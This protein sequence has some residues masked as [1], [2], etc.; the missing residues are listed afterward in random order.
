MKY[1]KISGIGQASTNQSA[2]NNALG[3]HASSEITSST[4][5]YLHD[6]M[7]VVLDLDPSKN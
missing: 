6:Y 3:R 1:D 7:H 4:M 2:C 5:Y